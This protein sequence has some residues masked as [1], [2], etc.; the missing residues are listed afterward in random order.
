MALEARGTRRPLLRWNGSS[1]TLPVEIELSERA[2]VNFVLAISQA[3]G[4]AWACFGVGLLVLLAGVIVGLRT[5]LVHAPAD[6]STKLDE[7][8]TKL[9][10]T[11]GHI[12]NATSAVGSSTLE[13]GAAA[14]EATA[15]AQAAGASAEAAK[16][17]L[18]QLQGIVGSLPENLRFAGLLVLIG[19]ALMSV[20]TIQFGGVPLF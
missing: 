1:G 18:E 14:A 2:D 13:S 7:V 5:S 10:E 17:A 6:A 8:K 11:K 20:A 12:E 3:D 9:E 16:S 4:V 19:T 15:S